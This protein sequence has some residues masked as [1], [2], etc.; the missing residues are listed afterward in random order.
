MEVTRPWG[1]VPGRKMPFYADV[2][3]RSDSLDR[4]ILFQLRFNCSTTRRDDCSRAHTGDASPDIRLRTDSEVIRGPAIIFIIR[5][6][7]LFRSSTTFI[8]IILQHTNNHCHPY[9]D[10]TTVLSD[11]CILCT[12]QYKL[13]SLW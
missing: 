8:C 13:A 1:G 6:S 7:I 10:S 12:S 9:I 3:T 5:F 2:T 11:I 4:L